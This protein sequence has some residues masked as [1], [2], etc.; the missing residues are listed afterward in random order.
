MRTWLDPIN[1]LIVIGLFFCA[2][3]NSKSL[4]FL[5]GRLFLYFGKISYALYLLHYPVLLAVKDLTI[6]DSLKFPAAL[7]IV[8]LLSHISNYVLEGPANRVIRNFGNSLNNR[9]AYIGKGD[10]KI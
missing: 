3:M 7:L 2:I 4:F 8:V 6:P 10:S 9:N 5:N 1:W